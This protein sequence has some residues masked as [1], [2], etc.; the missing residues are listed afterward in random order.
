MAD[1]SLPPWNPYDPDCPTRMMLDRIGDKWTVL[2]LGLLSA[3]PLRFNALRRQVP[4][5]SQKML[6]QT[7]KDM[8]RDGLVD[9]SAFATVPVTVEYTITPLGQS[10]AATVA[11]LVTWATRHADQVLAARARYQSR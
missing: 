2:V 3:G 11:Q 10:L 7:L 8:E 9:R 6:S 4:G 5:I 1:E